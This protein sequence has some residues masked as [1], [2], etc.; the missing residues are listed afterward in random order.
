MLRS[1]VST[2]HNI[3]PTGFLCHNRFLPGLQSNLYVDFNWILLKICLGLV[4]LQ[5]T[6]IFVLFCYT[7]F[8]VVNLY[9]VKEKKNNPKLVVSIM[10]E[11][12][13]EIMHQECFIL[14]L[15]S[16][17]DQLANSV[18]FPAEF[19]VFVFKYKR[20][21]LTNFRAQKQGKI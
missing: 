5:K 8:T 19:C 2:F 17:L 21:N 9:I 7:V 6:E 11:V 18:I 14:T 12:E 1:F 15:S 20:D 3:N 13:K 16:C 4:L 10:Q